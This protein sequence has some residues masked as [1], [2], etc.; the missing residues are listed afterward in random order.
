MNSAASEL[1]AVSMTGVCRL[2][3]RCTRLKLARVV[4]CFTRLLTAPAAGIGSRMIRVS[5]LQILIFRS[6]LIRILGICQNVCQK[7]WKHM[8]VVYGNRHR[9]PEIA[10]PSF[11]TLTPQQAP[12]YTKWE[13]YPICAQKESLFLFAFGDF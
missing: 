4:V 6:L 8:S 1:M 5:M 13:E 10:Y 12:G 11:A 9:N 2:G 3:K 7:E